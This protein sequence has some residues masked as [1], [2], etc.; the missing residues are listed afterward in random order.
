MVR[1]AEL[2]IPNRKRSGILNYRE[3]RSSQEEG[4]YFAGKNLWIH[5]RSPSSKSKYW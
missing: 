2:K 5:F 1:I 4:W 3:L